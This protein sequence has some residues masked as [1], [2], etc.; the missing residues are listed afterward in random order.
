MLLRVT[1]YGEPVLRQKGEPVSEFDDGLKQLA[2]DMLET[3]EAHEGVGLAAQQ[4]GLDL[5]FFVIDLRGLPDRQSLP[6]ILDGKQPPIDLIMPLVMANAKVERLPGPEMLGEEGCLSF[7][8][9][10]GDV[11]RADNIRVTYQDV[12]GARHIMEAGDWLARVI[13][14]E[15]DHTQGV[16]FIDH[17]KPSEKRR[18]DPQLKDLKRATNEWLAGQAREQET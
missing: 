1:Q 9:I 6:F 2:T 10:R 7:P 3:M 14:H 12:S 11:P 17:M 16:L 4:V 18:L 5:Q 13:Q 8:D 15:Y